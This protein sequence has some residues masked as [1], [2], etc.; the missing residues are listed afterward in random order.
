MA[1]EEDEETGENGAIRAAVRSAKKASKPV[2]IGQPER[3]PSS[4]GKKREKVKEKKKRGKAATRIGGAF[5]KEMG[6]RS[7]KEGV[8][9][10]KGDIIG[11]MGKKKG[12]KRKAK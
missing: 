8:R 11:G 10:R 12:M 3:K 7:V 2:K 1:M 9:A 5:D 6:R 4:A